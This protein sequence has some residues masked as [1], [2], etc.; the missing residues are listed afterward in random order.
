MAYANIDDYRAL[1]FAATF[2][3]HF[4]IVAAERIHAI[5][6]ADYY[7]LLMMF[8]AIIFRRYAIRR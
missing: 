7:A 5:I 8:S 2:S 6:A 1:H 4:A 3:L